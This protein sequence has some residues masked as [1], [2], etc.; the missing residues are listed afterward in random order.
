MILATALWIGCGGGTGPSQPNGLAPAPGQLAVT[1]AT[2]NFGS[3]AVG[4]SKS[5]SGTLTAGTADITVKSAAWNGE[6]YSLSGITFPATVPANQSIPFTVT[7]APQTAGTSPGSVSFVSNASNSPNTEMLTGTGA[8]PV[9]H[10]VTL[11]WSPSTSHVVGYN[12]YRGTLS[13]GPYAKLNRSPVRATNYTDSTVQSGLTYY[14]VA[15]SVGSK[16]VESAHSN[17]TTVVI[18]TP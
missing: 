11:S 2:M 16:M 3:L 18:P 8:E 12:I 14:Y 9:Q 13:G 1:P 10:S 17:Q 5:Q 4:S 15:T 6:G 7:F